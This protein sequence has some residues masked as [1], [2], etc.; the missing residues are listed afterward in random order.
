MV[1]F[2][3]KLALGWKPKAIVFIK[4]LTGEFNH[5]LQSIGT[6]IKFL[7]LP[8]YLEKHKMICNPGYSPIF[9]QSSTVRVHYGDYN[10]QPFNDVKQPQLSGFI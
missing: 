1:V 2:N 7:S 8:I 3:E 10:T 6:L 4:F 9:N 5:R